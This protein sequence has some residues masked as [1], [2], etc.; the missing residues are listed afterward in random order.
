MGV[1]G[2]SGDG[3]VRPEDE[4]VDGECS[5]LPNVLRCLRVCASLA[6][7]A[8]MDDG[9]ATVG[10]RGAVTNDA[11]SRG[12]TALAVASTGDDTSAWKAA[13]TSSSA[14][15]SGGREVR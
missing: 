15:S 6:T 3:H 5:G 14:L 4:L 10:C 12:P 13:A 2:W 1:E 8:S 11:T 7:A 9:T